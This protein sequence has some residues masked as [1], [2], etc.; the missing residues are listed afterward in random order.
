MTSIPDAPQKSMVRISLLRRLPLSIFLAFSAAIGF[1]T[2]Q[3]AVSF[4]QEGPLSIAS[5]DC[6]GEPEVV[7]ILNDG[8]SAQD[9]TGWSLVSDPIAAEVFDLS[10]VAD[11]AAGATVNIQSGPAASGVLVWSEDEVFR[12]DDASD[13][14]RLLDDSGATID[15]VACAVATPTPTA[16]PTATPTTSPG[17][18][19]NGGGPP[20]PSSGPLTVLVVTGAGLSG[21]ALMIMA[22]TL[23]PLVNLRSR[24]PR[25]RS[26]ARSPLTTASKPHAIPGSTLVLMGIGLAMI[27]LLVTLATSTRKTR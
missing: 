15:E 11:L 18:V 25:L 26:D 16:A 4:A 22:F 23:T 21:A 8:E 10:G 9:L 14:A 27:V 6:S 24:L 19:P 7:S 5:L 3:Q 17:D 2:L 1:A 20:A 13:F 12:D